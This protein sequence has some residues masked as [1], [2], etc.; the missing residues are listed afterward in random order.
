MKKSTWIGIYLFL[1]L[2]MPQK[3]VVA[4]EV[5]NNNVTT[6]GQETQPEGF[7]LNQ[8]IEDID[9]YFLNL[10]NQAGAGL[11]IIKRFDRNLEGYY[12]QSPGEANELYLTGICLTINF[13]TGECEGSG[14]Q[15]VNE[16]ALDFLESE[17]GISGD[18]VSFLGKFFDVDLLNGKIKTKGIKTIAGNLLGV[19][20]RGKRC[21][22]VFR[23]IAGTCASDTRLPVLVTKD[24]G[25]IRDSNRGS[26]NYRDLSQPTH[27]LLSENLLNESLDFNTNIQLANLY[28]REIARSVAFPFVEQRGQQWLGDN[29]LENY[30]LVDE[31]TKIYQQIHELAAA[32]MNS[33][34]TQDVMKLNT[35]A[36]ERNSNIALNQSILGV[37]TQ[38]SLLS[39]QQQT[40]YSMQ[41]QANISDTLDRDIRKQQNQEEAAIFRSITQPLYLPGFRYM[42]R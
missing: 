4:Q 24:M 6:I 13:I 7:D 19:N 10:G 12:N 3:Q 34:V 35:L 18:T 38:G 29:L 5:E 20:L 42:Y 36:L 17:L 33:S 27:S 2:L 26:G 28:D 37:K 40:A 11:R 21:L 23:T 39:L 22:F 25:G 9:N 31:N 15:Y 1:L 41:I 8:S 14:E 30:L 32:S 16:L